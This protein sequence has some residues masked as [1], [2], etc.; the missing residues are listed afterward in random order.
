MS[1]GEHFLSGTQVESGL[2]AQIRSLIASGK[3]RAAKRAVYR[4][5]LNE[6]RMLSDRDLQ[7]LGLH[8]SMIREVAL[9]A[10]KLS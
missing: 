5:T 2:F 1:S 9:D 8:R 7:D 10:A 3:E 6:L 4:R